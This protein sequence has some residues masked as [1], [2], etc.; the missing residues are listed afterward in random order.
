[1]THRKQDEFSLDLSF[2]ASVANI[3]RFALCGRRMI[4]AIWPQQERLAFDI[5]LCLVEALSNVLFHAHLEKPNNRLSFQIR[6]R[7]NS[8]CVR[9]YDKGDGFSLAEQ[10]A[11]QQDLYQINGRGLQLMKGLMDRL[12]YFRHPRRNQL[13]LEKFISIHETESVS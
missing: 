2:S 5:E 1:M 7:K 8:L 11:K 13:L 4:E 9:V 6:K 10:F 3:R 12:E